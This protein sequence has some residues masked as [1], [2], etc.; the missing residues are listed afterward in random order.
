MWLT[1]RII[2][3]YIKKKVKELKGINIKDKILEYINEHKEEI[4]EKAKEALDKFIKNLV[5]KIVEKIKDK[6]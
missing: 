4:I 2:N 3:N 5:D 1:D 6:I